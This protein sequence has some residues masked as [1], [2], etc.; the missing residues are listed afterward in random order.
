MLLRSQTAQFGVVGHSDL[1]GVGLSQNV[2]LYGSKSFRS[3]KVSKWRDGLMIKAL[4]NTT[5]SDSTENLVLS[6]KVLG[7]KK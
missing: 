3:V 6:K 5:S 4:M 7:L 1:F 2:N